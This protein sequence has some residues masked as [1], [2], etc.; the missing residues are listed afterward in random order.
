MAK[1]AELLSLRDL[2]YTASIDKTLFEKLVFMGNFETIAPD[3]KNGKNLTDAHIKNYVESLLPGS[4][5]GEVDPSI[6]EKVL[7][8]FPLQINIVNADV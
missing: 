6:I 7:V 2:Q 1:Q 5:D 3:V 8:G 4:G